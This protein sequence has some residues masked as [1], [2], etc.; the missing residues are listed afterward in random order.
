MVGSKNIFKSN[1][2][3]LIISG[4]IISGCRL[5]FIVKRW[6]YTYL[7]WGRNGNAPTDI[8]SI[9]NTVSLIPLLGRFGKGS[10]IHW[11]IHI[12]EPKNIFIGENVRLRRGCDMTGMGRIIIEDNVLIG[13]HVKF[14]TNKHIYIN[15]YKPIMEQ[16]TTQG[17]IKIEKNAWIG[18]DC[19]LLP[20]VTIGEH[21]VVG[22]GSVVTKNVE[23][24]TVVAGNPAKLIKKIEQLNSNF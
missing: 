8:L 23:P 17:Y 5:F 15:I 21:A 6:I 10:L 18:G 11:S 3:K 24:Y 13:P 19:I 16:E 7:I 9:L 1:F 4:L 14:Y 20:D 12:E 22:A 2:W